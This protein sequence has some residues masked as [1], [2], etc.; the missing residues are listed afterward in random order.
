MRNAIKGTMFLMFVAI[1]LVSGCEKTPVTTDPIVYGNMTGNVTEPVDITDV[2]LTTPIVNESVIVN[3]T[4]IV[5]ETLNST[6]NNSTIVIVDPVNNEN[7]DYSEYRD[8]NLI[9]DSIDD[10]E[11]LE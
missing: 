5:N 6:I 1:L 11:S 7:S 3:N 2:N 9:D 10:L 8:T 4:I